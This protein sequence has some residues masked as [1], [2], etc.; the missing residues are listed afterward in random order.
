MAEHSDNR[1]HAIGWEVGCAVTVETQTVHNTN[2]ARRR[3]VDLGG[4][5]SSR[6]N[7]VLVLHAK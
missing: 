6:G 1:L 5:L 3:E 4:R 7:E 2:R